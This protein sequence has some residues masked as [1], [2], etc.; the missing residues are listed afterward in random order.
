MAK[1]VSVRVVLAMAVVKSLFLHQMDVTN[2]FLHGDL[3]EKV[4]VALPP[5]FH[6]NRRQLLV[7]WF[8]NLIKACMD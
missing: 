4:Y 8:V 3:D 1:S 2:A 6:S 7:Q 5:S